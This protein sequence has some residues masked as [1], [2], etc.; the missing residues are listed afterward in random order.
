MDKKWA[1]KAHKFF[2]NKMVLYFTLLLS[3]TTILGF[4][5]LKNWHS[6]VLFVLMAVILYLRNVRH[7]V[8]LF[9]LIAFI[10]FLRNSSLFL[11]ELPN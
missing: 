8:V 5:F 4:L 7:A 2:E 9:V 11:P 10:L 6:V 1:T 3:V